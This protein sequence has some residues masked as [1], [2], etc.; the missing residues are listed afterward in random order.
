MSIYREKDG[1]IVR[2]YEWWPEKQLLSTQTR[3]QIVDFVP[4]KEFGY[5]LFI[6]NELQFTEKDEYIYH[7]ALIHPCLANSKNMS[8]VLVMGG[9]DGCAV[10][11]IL[12]WE[13]FSSLQSIRVIDWDEILTD[14]FREK[15]SYLNSNSFC[16]PLV[17][18]ENTDILSL[19]EKEKR[20]YDCI[21][22]DLVDPHFETPSSETLWKKALSLAQAWIDKEGSL[23]LNAGGMYPWDVTEVNSLIHLVKNIFPCYYVH[24]YKVFV[25]SFGREWCFLLLNHSPHVNVNILP[26]GLRYVDKFT[27]K[28]MYSTGWCKEFFSNINLNL[29]RQLEEDDD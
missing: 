3:K 19:S 15:Y 7:E 16:S 20:N 24:L 23:V 8:N 5:A 21:F 26:P 18:I 27:W 14:F 13:H 4:T 12:R 10:R 17:S 29:S 25:P 2:E 28:S 9:G 1:H 22:I 11:E 6:D